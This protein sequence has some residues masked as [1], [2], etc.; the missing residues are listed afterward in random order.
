MIEE[1]KKKEMERGRDKEKERGKEEK[2]YL[3]VRDSVL[4][5]LESAELST[6]T[7]I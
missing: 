3:L 2:V 5:I 1:G 4:F 6:E 7:K